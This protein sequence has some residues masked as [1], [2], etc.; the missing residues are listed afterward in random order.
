MTRA[1]VLTADSAGERMGGSAIR[2]YE[3]A[4]VLSRHMDV[5]LAANRAAEPTPPGLLEVPLFEYDF[6]DQRPLRDLVRGA[7]V[8]V[9]EP[10]WPHIAHELERSGARLI[11]DITNAE[12]LEVLES[13]KKRGPRVRRGAITLTVDRIVDAMHR[14]HHL[15]CVSEQQRDLWLGTMLAE[16][17]ISPDLYDSDPSLRSVL[18][19]V[20]F[21]LPSDEPVAQADGPRERFPQVAQDD[22]IVLWNA[23]IWAWFDAPAAIRAVARL[24]ERRPGVR[25]VFMA[26]SARGS[27]GRATEEAMTLARELGLMDDT[28]LFNDD[29]VP[30]ARRADWLLAADC[31]VSTHHEH[32]ET[33]FAFRRRLLDCFWARL[34]TVCT[35]GDELGELIER[36]DL[37][38]AVPEHDDEALAD[39]LER[40][41]ERGKDS[42]R[43]ALDV[44]AAAFAWD[45]VAEPLVRW[46]TASERTQRIGDGAARRPGQAARAAGFRAAVEVLR[47]TGRDWPRL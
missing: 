42:Y 4:R 35:R 44:T 28:V 37:G 10:P 33:R 22:E 21:G 45:R 14:G 2:M 11:F 12:P 41:L 6:I 47:A 46:A 27:A 32:L 24:A 29:W 18:D 39:A 19:L 36:D 15:M 3:L 13:S 7:E 23:G 20:P 1:V 38:A 8:V 5:V 9:A 34:P 16:R 31:V 30:Y 43:P 17:L 25:L 26:A 40:V